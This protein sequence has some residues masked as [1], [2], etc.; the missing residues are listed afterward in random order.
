MKEHLHDSAYADELLRLAEADLDSAK[1]LLAAKARTEN[2]CFFAEQCVEKSIKVVLIKQ[3]I[4]FGY[5]HDLGYL[6]GKLPAEKWPPDGKKIMGLELYAAQRR[7]EEGPYP[8]TEEEAEE[9]IQIATRSFQ[10][11]KQFTKS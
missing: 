11:A 7:Y 9:S 5:L 1:K 4:P 2:A 8:A 10:W 6:L 3:Q